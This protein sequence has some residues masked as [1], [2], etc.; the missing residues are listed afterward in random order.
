V[1]FLV[2]IALCV[3]TTWPSSLLAYVILF[4]VWFSQA[5][6]F[7]K[8]RLL[9]VDNKLCNSDSKE[10]VF[11]DNVNTSASNSGYL[12]LDP[13]SY[14]NRPDAPDVP[15]LEKWI[16]TTIEEHVRKNNV[17]VTSQIVR[18]TSKKAQIFKTDHVVTIAIPAKLR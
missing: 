12:E 13:E 16:L 3:N 1:R 7:L 11:L 17:L 2:K 5:P 8:A 14:N 4:K 10:L 9:N 18:K 6:Y 15:K